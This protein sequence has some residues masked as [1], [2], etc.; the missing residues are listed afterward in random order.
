MDCGI[1]KKAVDGKDAIWIGGLNP[2]ILGKEAGRFGSLKPTIYHRSCYLPSY[3]KA[4]GPFAKDADM[5]MNTIGP[6]IG[7][8]KSAPEEPIR[9]MASAFFIC[10]LASMVLLAGGIL[11]AGKALSGTASIPETI[12]A[13]FAI[14]IGAYLFI[15]CASAG[16]ALLLNLFI[17]LRSR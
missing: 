16:C 13:P 5:A 8:S 6:F 10:L 14:L 11:V 17:A 7:I 1:C 15:F 4:V 2:I 12:A 9:S 3:S